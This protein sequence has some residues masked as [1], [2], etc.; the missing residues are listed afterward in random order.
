MSFFWMPYFSASAQ[1][2]RM[3]FSYW[4]NPS[5]EVFGSRIIL[6][7]IVSFVGVVAISISTDALP[8]PDALA[9]FFHWQWP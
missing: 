2:F 6:G 1:I 4:M 3:F 7:T 9:G 5:H 8:L